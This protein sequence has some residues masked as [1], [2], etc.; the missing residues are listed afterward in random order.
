MEYIAHIK[1]EYLQ[2]TWKHGNKHL[3]ISEVV[4]VIL[5]RSFIQLASIRAKMVFVWFVLEVQLKN[6]QL[7][8]GVYSSY[9]IGVFTG[10]METWE[11]ARTLHISEVVW[12]ILWRSFIQLASIRAKMVFVWFVLVPKTILARMDANWIKDRHNMTHTTSLICK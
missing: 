3:H 9:K 5:W 11:Q 2:G 6:K 12:V 4:W 7:H 10:Y 1:L 8:Y